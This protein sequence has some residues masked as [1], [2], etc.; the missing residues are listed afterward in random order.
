MW[1][2]SLL[3]VLHRKHAAMQWYAVTGLARQLHDELQPAE[4]F[5]N[6]CSTQEVLDRCPDAANKQSCSAFFDAQTVRRSNDLYIV[7]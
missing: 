3:S 1:Y 4:C 2:A 5:W 6:I 7:D